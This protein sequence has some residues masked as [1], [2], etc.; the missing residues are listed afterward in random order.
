MDYEKKTE[1]K[2][3]NSK[4]GMILMAMAV[5]ACN[6]DIR[7]EQTISFEKIAPQLLRDGSVQLKAAASSGL[8]VTFVS[9]DENIATVEGDRAVFHAAG[10]T[11]I[12]AI[13]RGNEDFYE[14]PDVFQSLLVRDWDPDKKTQTIDFELPAVWQISV[15]GQ[16]LTLNAA[17]SSGL[18]VKYSVSGANVGRILNNT[19]I[20]YVYHAGEGGCDF[21]NKYTTTLI[22]SASQDGNGE[23]NPADNVA[24]QIRIF[25]DVLH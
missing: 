22:F 9:A 6:Q 25:G 19:S 1:M 21:R 14:A 5:M 7:Q 2:I 20:F 17:A 16:M 4:T 11:L 8:P 23:Y 18:P 3:W 13:Q 24:R 10:S 15:N 12:Y